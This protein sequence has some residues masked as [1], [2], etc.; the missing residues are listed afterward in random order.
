MPL[1]GRT[2]IKATMPL[3][4]E[5]SEH[6]ENIINTVQVSKKSQDGALWFP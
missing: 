3:F 5:V 6:T 2:S 4:S 1:V